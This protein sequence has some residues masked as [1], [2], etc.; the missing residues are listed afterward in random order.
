VCTD[1][2][3]HLDNLHAIFGELLRVAG[4][5]VVLSLPNNWMAARVPIRRGHGNFAHYGL[6]L[7]RPADRHKW[8][9]NLQ[10][11]RD[12]VLGW[13]ARRG[14]CRLLEERATE[15]PKA[16]PLRALRRMRYPSQIRYLNRYAHTW[17]AVLQ[18]HPL[19]VAQGN[20]A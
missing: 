9:F 11:A 2:L 3:E 7:E 17:W 4:A 16:V 8:F 20:G 15:K 13:T 18:K 12:F 1:V 5:F 10:Q 14:D 19:P 6:P